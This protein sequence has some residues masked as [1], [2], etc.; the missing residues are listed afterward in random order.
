[1]TNWEKNEEK[2]NIEDKFLIEEIDALWKEIFNN[3]LG[4]KLI[5][6]TIK[7][8]DE[9]Y[10]RNKCWPEKE[11][12][13]RI[14]RYLPINKIKVVIIGQD[15]YHA[16]EVADGFAFSTEIK[17]YIPASLKNIFLELE[18]DIGCKKPKTGNLKKWVKEGV[19]LFNTSLTVVENKPLSHL[20]IWNE[21][22][23]KI[24]KFLK[25]FN[26]KIIWVFLGEKA[27]KIG[28]RC[29]INNSEI[30][31]RTSHPSPYSANFGFFGS[32]I[33]SNINKKLEY[34]GEKKI[35]WKL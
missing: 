13:F 20:E 11:K 31:I 35:N 7:K 30:I 18:K 27:K 6:E 19:F 29:N 10:K 33:F 4:K 25:K 14:F 34:I 22:S 5:N 21:F 24:I 17:N 32:K 12:I 9:E 28:D 3:H 15:P 2:K 1:M 26:E 23:E 8:I 16:P